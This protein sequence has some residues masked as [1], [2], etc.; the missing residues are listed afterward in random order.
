MKSLVFLSIALL[1]LSCR[2][3]KP[4]PFAPSD[5]IVTV[6]QSY[7]GS[8]P[9]WTV[10]AVQAGRIVVY[11]QSGRSGV[12]DKLLGDVAISS[13]QEAKL[14]QA[15]IS[16]PSASKGRI[17]FSPDVSDGVSL[18]IHFTKDGSLRDDDVAL[19]NLWR[20]EFRDLCTS[21]SSMLPSTL[22]ITFEDIVSSR[23]DQDRLRVISRPI[24][25][26]RAPKTEPNQSLQPTGAS[27]RG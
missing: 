24:K 3:E 20:P 16:I 25:E 26:Y 5:R 18:S 14:K 27:A 12:P 2:A 9:H 4:A 11:E 22:K 15:V 1:S 13:D 23:P 17:W 10:W 8:G 21:I 6:V 7:G 19:E